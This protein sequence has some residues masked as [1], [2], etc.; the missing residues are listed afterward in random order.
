MKSNNESNVIRESLDLP[1][2]CLAKL[3]SGIHHKQ[4]QWLVVALDYDQSLS[5][6][7]YMEYT[8]PDPAVRRHCDPSWRSH[9]LG[10][11]LVHEAHSQ[12]QCA[13]L[14]H[15]H[16]HT[17][18]HS[19]SN[20]LF[21]MQQINQPLPQSGSTRLGCNPLEESPSPKQQL[22]FEPRACTSFSLSTIMASLPALPNNARPMHP[23]SKLRLQ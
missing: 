5:E 9:H 19:S 4:L 6:M 20:S 13:P 23:F 15:T 14:L 17:H 1:L 12:M 7:S 22:E 21:L 16:T 11:E 10:S 2:L 3:D 18:T 8:H